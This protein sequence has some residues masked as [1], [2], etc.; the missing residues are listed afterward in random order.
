MLVWLVACVRTP[1]E[2]TP[3]PADLG[4]IARDYVRLILA[5]GE[6]EPGYVDAYYGPPEWAEAEH[7]AVRPVPALIAD[8]DRLLASLDAIDPGPG[9]GLAPID[10]RRRAFLIAHLKAARFRL[11]TVTPAPFRD[12]AEALFGVR[13]DPPPLSTYD[14]LLA[15]VAAVVP[16]EGPLEDR[17]AAF[18]A[19]YEI[20]ADKVEAVMAAAIAECRRRTVAHL[21][22]PAGETFTLERV[23]GKS[24][25][26]Y[27]WYKGHATSL[28]QVN[29]D[30]PVRVDRAVDLG[31]HEGYP[32][33]H[34]HNVLLEH[35]LV[36][37]RGWVELSVYPLY[38]PMSFV[39][40]GVGNYGIT[41][42]FPGEER[43]AFERDVLYPLAGLDPATAA[44]YAVVGAARKG[45]D[46][47]RIRIAADYL[48]GAIDRATAVDLVRRTLLVSPARADQIVSFMDE[49]RSYV[50]NYGLGEAAVEAA[51]E[52][53]GAAD[54][55]RWAA[56]GAI[57]SEPT[58]PSD[59]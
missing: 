30:L 39:A 23:T 9:G 16:G 46:P 41:L 42:A 57:L 35:A 12:E 27:N 7:A 29:T 28:I 6:H 44:A 5:I 34:T 14:P 40:E 10:V 59:L 36:D 53:R 38:S 13:P 19:R 11:A 31:C 2:P 47:A 15:K 21:A 48:D 24:W 45:L 22:L 32:G 51:V 33:H 4:P 58:L 37:G 55:A 56:L 43:L 52:S 8:A 3:T 49:Y 18:D 26:G 50:V 1:I 25:A 54:A 17:V 20:P